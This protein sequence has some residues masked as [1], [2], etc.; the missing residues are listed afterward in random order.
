MTL[1]PAYQSG[2]RQPPTVQPRHLTVLL[3]ATAG[4]RDSLLEAEDFVAEG[5]HTL[6]DLFIP[7]SVNDDSVS[8]I[9]KA[10][11]RIHPDGVQF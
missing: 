8:A 2:L 1:L 3:E 4:L 10:L 6:V 5:V 7:G 9:C 11:G